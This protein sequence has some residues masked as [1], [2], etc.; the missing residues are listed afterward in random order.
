MIYNWQWRS[1]EQRDGGL[2]RLVDRLG[3]L[4]RIY[5]ESWTLV[6]ALVRCGDCVGAIGVRDGLLHVW[7]PRGHRVRLTCNR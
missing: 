3:V 6:A 4:E 5:S 2:L 7:R 1:R